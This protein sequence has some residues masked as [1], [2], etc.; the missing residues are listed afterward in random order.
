MNDTVP[1]NREQFIAFKRFSSRLDSFYA[2]LVEEKEEFEALQKLFEVI[3]FFEWLSAVERKFNL[4]DLSTVA[5]Q[6][7]LSLKKLRE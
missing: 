7:E 2:G 1:K 5:N 3:Y 6:L 4:D